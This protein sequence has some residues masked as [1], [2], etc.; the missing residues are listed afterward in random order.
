MSKTPT[1]AA[2]ETAARLIAAIDA[3]EPLLRAEMPAG[4]RAAR[5]PDAVAAELFRLGLFR[6]WIPRRYGGL[7]L[8]L[9]AALAVYEAVA[10]RDG[11]VGWSVMIGAGGGLFAA[12]LDPGVA[13]RL[14][15]GPRALVAG[16]GAAAGIARRVSGGYRVS[17]RWRYASG[18]DHA[19]VFTA[20][21]RVPDS[22]QDPAAA[23]VRAMAF[24][25]EAV[26]IHRTWDSSGLCATG[27]HDIAVDEVF[28]PEAMSFSVHG[29]PPRETGPLYGMP[30]ATLTELPVSA[31]ALGI[32]RRACEEFASLAQAKCAPG[33]TVRLGE[34][35][36]AQAALRRARET[37]A[38][39]SAALQEQA[40]LAWSEALAGSRPAPHLAAL[41]TAACVEGI[42]ALVGAVGEL[43][44]LAGM[45]ALQRDDPFAVAWQD[46][47]AAA[48]HYSVSPLQLATAAQEGA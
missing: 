46:L 29:D 11:S 6:L 41:R 32:A 43:A 22:G 2:G 21:C 28:V 9:T 13:D 7:E 10:R 25:P 24:A 15:A 20:N 33:S 27:S 39:A 34:L 31:V 26:R 19:S 36:L 40:A 8:P 44:P 47:N 30:F 4:R 42:R 5:L 12:L 23:P 14:F 3:L 48:A 45:N 37:I 17:G 38:A 35:D 16:S 1:E 18:A